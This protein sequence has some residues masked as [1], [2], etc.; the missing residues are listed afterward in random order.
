VPTALFFRS[1][2]AALPGLL[3]GCLLLLAFLFLAFLLP[4]LFFIQLLL[5][6][7]GT[8]RT[9]SASAST[10]LRGANRARLLTASAALPALLSI[11]RRQTGSRQ[12][13]RETKSCEKFLHLLFV[14]HLP[15]FLKLQRGFFCLAEKPV[16][17]TGFLFSIPLSCPVEMAV[18]KTS[19]ERGAGEGYQ[20][21]DIRKIIG[22]RALQTAPDRI[23]ALVGNRE[24]G[25]LK[26]MDILYYFNPFI[27][28]CNRKVHL[29]K[30]GMT[31]M[32][33]L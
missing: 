26:W 20:A 21:I 31:G 19:R 11:C 29:A 7:G 10:G 33:F 3:L 25:R 8:D 23:C 27:I 32:K 13:P 22:E 17:A 4:G 28:G 6:L 9:R 15:P 2:S 16:Q 1:A 12:K 5:F 24:D 30:H 18:P 14:H